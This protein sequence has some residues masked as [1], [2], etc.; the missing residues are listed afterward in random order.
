MEKKKRLIIMGA[1]ANGPD[2][3]VDIIPYLD[4]KESNVLILP[5]IL[6]TEYFFRRQDL[7]NRTHFTDH[8]LELIPGHIYVGVGRSPLRMS[9]YFNLTINDNKFSYYS[10]DEIPKDRD[11]IDLVMERLAKKY[12]E[13]CIGVI[14]SGAGESGV[15]G[16]KA[17]QENGGLTMALKQEPELNYVHSLNGGSSTL[18][19]SGRLIPHC[20]CGEMPEASISAGVVDFEC[21]TNDL[22]KKINEMCL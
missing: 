14:L 7:Q 4:I 19:E 10:D 12:G 2:C 16:L 5:H 22:V 1:S 15:E 9:G 21:G 6:S 17:I 13:R 11:L 20:Y 3:A 8:R 18:Q